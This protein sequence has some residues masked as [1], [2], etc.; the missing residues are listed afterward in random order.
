MTRK[1]TLQKRPGPLAL[2][3]RA[4]PSVG[5]CLTATSPPEFSAAPARARDRDR[6]RRPARP[7]RPAA[8]VLVLGLLLLGAAAAEAQTTPR[9]LVSNSA[10]AADDSADTSGN[11]HAQ[12]FHTGGATN[13]Y[14]LTSVHVNSE[15]GTVKLSRIRPFC[16]RILLDQRLRINDLAV[17][18]GGEN[19][20]K[21][22]NLTVPA[23]RRDSLLCPCV[24]LH[25]P[26]PYLAWP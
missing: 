23:N 24:G 15:D 18:A 25:G 13:G 1:K 6:S 2:I 3:M 4:E 9:I 5:Y 22:L 7:G 20:A 14:T 11:D 26:A 8:T 21:L 17:A 10:Q 16:G 12:L 19:A